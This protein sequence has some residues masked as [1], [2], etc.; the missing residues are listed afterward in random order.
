MEGNVSTANTKIESDYNGLSGKALSKYSSF[1]VSVPKMNK[2]Y[3]YYTFRLPKE[4]ER[5]ILIKILEHGSRK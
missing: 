5:Q 2:K 1:F 3:S 4:D